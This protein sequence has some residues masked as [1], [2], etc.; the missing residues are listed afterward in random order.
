MKTYIT[1]LFVA[2][3]VS[4]FA[5]DENEFKLGHELGLSTSF[6]QNNILNNTQNANPYSVS[7][8]LIT[9]QLGIR[10]GAGGTFVQN[11]IQ[12]D[13]FADNQREVNYTTDV[14]IGAEW[15]KS[16]KGKWLIY[17]GLD[18]IGTQI[19][20]KTII[21]SGFD[22]VTDIS[23]TLGYGGGPV[24]GLQF[25]INEHLSVATEGVAYFRNLETTTA[26]LFEN[27][28]DFDDDINTTT[29]QD[30]VNQL[31]SSIYIIYRF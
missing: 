26:R 30:L 29:S 20:D 25:Y 14:R 19:V 15:R 18:V 4:L 31:P 28:P 7:Y 24:V 16:I 13:G 12:E 5:Q 2:I 10:I 8:K 22:K 21:D 9:H 3:G 1:I 11:K 23:S 6:F 17:A 27:F